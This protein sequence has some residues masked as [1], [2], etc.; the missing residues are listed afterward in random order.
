MKIKKKEKHTPS[1][2]LFTSLATR[3]LTTEGRAATPVER[4]RRRVVRGRRNCILVGYL[5]RF[6]GWVLIGG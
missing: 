2:L 6:R 1:Q 3:L 5:M 4:V